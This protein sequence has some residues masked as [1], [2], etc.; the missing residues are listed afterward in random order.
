MALHTDKN[1]SI[2]EKSGFARAKLIVINNSVCIFYT[3]KAITIVWSEA[4]LTSI[5]TFSTH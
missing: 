4:L 3:T 5:V 2:G 1:V